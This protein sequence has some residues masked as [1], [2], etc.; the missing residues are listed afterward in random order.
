MSK[1]NLENYKP[2]TP[3]K[4]SCVTNFPFIEADFDAITNYEL[5]S[6]VV[7]Y[8]N[9]VGSDVTALHDAYIALRSYV[10]DELEAQNQKI[11]DYF[12]DINIQTFVDNKIDELIENGDF[13]DMLVSAIEEID[14]EFFDT[15][16]KINVLNFGGALIIPPI[17]STI[18]ERFLN[19]ANKP[20]VL[21]IIN[22]LLKN[23][24]DTYY[25]V[26][27]KDT[28][29]NTYKIVLDLQNNKAVVNIDYDLKRDTEIVDGDYYLKTQDFN[30]TIT[31]GVATNIQMTTNRTFLLYEE[32]TGADPYKVINVLDFGV[33][34]VSESARNGLNSGLVNSTNKAMLIDIINTMVNNEETTYYFV[35]KSEEHERV[36]KMELQ[37][38][39]VNELVSAR[40]FVNY[41]TDTDSTIKYGDTYLLWGDLAVTL[42]INMITVIDLEISGL[43]STLVYKLLKTDNTTSYT[44]A[45]SYNP[46]TK[47]YVDANA[48]PKGEAVNSINLG[49]T[50]VS[51]NNPWEMSYAV[52]QDTNVKNKIMTILNYMLDNSLNMYFFRNQYEDYTL[53]LYAI[54]ANNILI[55]QFFY[56]D[57]VFDFTAKSNMDLGSSYLTR[58][59]YVVTI[60]D[61]HVTD[62]GFGY[63]S[64]SRSYNILRTDNIGQLTGYDSS[65]TQT[66]KN[67]NG[68]LTWVDDV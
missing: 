21:E 50:L 33:S 23:E 34:I 3:F 14:P 45:N 19:T 53:N 65:K 4:L 52:F 64:S 44:P 6:L 20:K 25:F 43:T 36:F 5:L 11:E 59:Q 39:N 29:F 35:N 1:P 62:I 68:T 56:I 13:S 26:N 10:I 66:L 48:L 49:V 40:I 63:S 41:N 47:D 51:D 24:K 9:N 61:G 8:L 37:F 2:L 38:V 30:L 32:S 12:D 67:V 57:V 42:D 31:S 22:E 15:A 18:N 55:N 46:A 58:Q 54:D 7:E 17:R 27:T 28:L 16:T 60:V